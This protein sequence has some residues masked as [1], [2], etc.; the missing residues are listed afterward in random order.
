MLLEA[1]YF[2]ESTGRVQDEIDSLSSRSFELHTSFKLL[3][4]RGG[5]CLP[6]WKKAS[7]LERR[8]GLKGDKNL[9]FPAPVA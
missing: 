8:K 4:G 3:G 6:Y 2:L 5:V 1:L 7:A 9:H